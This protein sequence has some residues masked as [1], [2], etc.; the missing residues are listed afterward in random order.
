[1]TAPKNQPKRSVLI[2]ARLITAIIA[3]SG[4]EGMLWVLGYPSW[5][6]QEL[7]AVTDQFEP[8]AELGW[9]NREGIFDLTGPL[10]KEP[11]RY[12]NWSHGRRATAEQEPQAGV[13]RPE[14]QFFGD[15]YVQGYGLS[16]RETFAWLFQQKHP[17]LN[18]SNFG[19]GAYGTYQ[20]YLAMRESVG[21]ASQV[22]YLF[23]GFHEERNVAAPSWLRVTKAPPPRLTFPYAKIRGGVLAEGRSR[24]ELV[25]SL[26]RRLRTVAMMQD[27]YMMA[28]SYRRVRSKRRVT[29]MLLVEMNEVVRARGGRF[30]VLLFDL[31]PEQRRDYRR[32]LASRQIPFIDCDRPELNDRTLRLPDGHPAARLNEL[33]SGWIE[34]V[35]V[36]RFRGN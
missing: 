25:W 8:D 16:D 19:T 24:G 3:V 34:Q 6:G 14:V 30:A 1:M 27:Y 32:F 22:F 17:E 12:T 2:A 23:N 29:E 28:E 20:S 18:V 31:T 10:R 36:T 21:G 26:S 13:K 5:R 33:L 35:Q 15:S 11:F 9:R 4:A 7:L